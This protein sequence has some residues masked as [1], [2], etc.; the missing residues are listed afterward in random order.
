VRG[1]LPFLGVPGPHNQPGIS[2]A[3][4]LPSLPG[5]PGTHNQPKVS[6]LRRLPHLPEVLDLT[7][8]RSLSGDRTSLSLGFLGITISMESLS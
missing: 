2:W 3:R 8:S 7:T 1:L 6:Q 5:V 4:R